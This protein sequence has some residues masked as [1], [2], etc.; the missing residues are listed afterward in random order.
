MQPCVGQVRV[1]ERLGAIKRGLQHRDLRVEHIGTGRHAGGESFA[2]H[3]PRLGRGTN[4]IVGRGYCGA[5][6]LNLGQAL[7]DLE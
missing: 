4:R 7:T 2:D 6:R 3:P 5:A 1:R